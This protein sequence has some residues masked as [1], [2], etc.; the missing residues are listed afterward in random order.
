[1]AAA[2]I[3]IVFY[4]VVVVLL[5][6]SGWVV[7]TKADKPGW[8]AIVP[9]YNIIVMLEIVGRPTWWIFLLLFCPPVSLVLGIIMAIDLA[10]SFGK[11]GGYAVGLILLPF[12]FYPMLAFG[13]ARYLGPQGEGA[14]R[15]RKKIRDERYYDDGDGDDGDEDDRPRR[16]VSARQDR[17]DDFDDEDDRPR[18]KAGARR[19]DDFEDEEPPRPTA[20][21]PRAAPPPVPAAPP[22]KSAPASAGGSSLVQCSNCNRKLKVP[23]TAV[24][25]K[26]KCPSCGSIFVA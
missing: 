7:F 15:R 9:I 14:S 17:D 1:M 3:L 22:A 16:K 6:A 13:D 21:K 5:F 18:K 26:V 25:K 2:V 4:V 19:D 8:A 20:I 12:V 10:K 24:G 23:A 11:G